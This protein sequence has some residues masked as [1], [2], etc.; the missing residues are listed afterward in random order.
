MPFGLKNAPRIFQRKMDGLFNHLSKFC[1]VYIDDI[2]VFSQNEKDHFKHLRQ[3]FQILIDNSLVISKKK[4]VLNKRRI[5]FLG[6]TIGDGMIEL[7]PHIVEKLLNFPDK[8]KDKNK[9]N[10]KN[11]FK[12]F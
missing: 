10:K 6:H 2:L 5:E 9:K 12:P 7:Q 11:S 3:V 8:L 4:L 1:I